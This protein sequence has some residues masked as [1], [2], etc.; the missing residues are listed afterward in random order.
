M[1]CQR[2]AHLRNHLHSLDHSDLLAIAQTV[3][4]RNRIHHS[5]GRRHEGSGRA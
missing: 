2:A 4:T 3:K 1:I 5:L